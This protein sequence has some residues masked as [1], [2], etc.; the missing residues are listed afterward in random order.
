METKGVTRAYL[1][2]NTSVTAS[3][4]SRWLSGTGS[5]SPARAKRIAEILNVDVLDLS[6]KTIETADIVDLRQRLGLTAE[7]A[8][9]SAGL[10]KQQIYEIESAITWPSD[11]RLSELAETYEQT[12]PVLRS[13]WIRRRISRFGRE[14]LKQ[15]PELR[16]N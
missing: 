6:G 16:D 14:S 2:A 10:S 3:V 9:R 11:K 1:A 4:I 5:P 15:I 7:E 8:G 13:A 12:L